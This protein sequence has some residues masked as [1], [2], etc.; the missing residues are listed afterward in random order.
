MSEV[1][2]SEEERKEIKKSL[3]LLITDMRSLW[4][5]SEQN[6]ID[7]NLGRDII[8]AY[9]WHLEID[10]KKIDIVHYDWDGSSTRENLDYKGKGSK[11]LFFNYVHAFNFIKNYDNIRKKL[12][13]EVKANL[14]KKHD[15]LKKLEEVNKIY[16]KEASIDIQFPETKNP[17]P[18]EVCQEDGKN[19]G[20]I[21]FGDR[22]IKI[23]TNGSIC[24]IDKDT[25]QELPRVKRK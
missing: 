2:F 11:Q 3:N 9:D 13:Y 7:I 22:T 10:S 18:I 14:S 4:D 12:E 17:L 16:D 24:L 6:Y 5:I 15:G 20:I 25:K 19:I 8:N 1:N 23:I 21:N